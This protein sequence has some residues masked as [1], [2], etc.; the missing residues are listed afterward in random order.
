[1]SRSSTRSTPYGLFAGVS[2]G[3]F[4]D[5]TKIVLNEKESIKI[6][7]ADTQWVC[8]L[9]HEIENNLEIAYELKVT[10]NTNCYRFGNRIKNPY[11]SNGG[12]ENNNINLTT[13]NN[14]KYSKLIEIIE[15]GVHQKLIQKDGLY[16]KLYQVQI[17]VYDVDG[18]YW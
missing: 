14:L 6:I 9:V 17:G 3:T 4:D 11:F 1:M 5:K 10:F 15:R 8:H 2:L 16:K 13:E 18:G 7:K 12:D